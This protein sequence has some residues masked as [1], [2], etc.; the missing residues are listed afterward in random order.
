MPVTAPAH[1]GHGSIARLTAAQVPTSPAHD[2][3]PLVKLAAAV[4]P[5]PLVLVLVPLTVSVARTLRA[6]DVGVDAIAL[7]AMAGALA[8]GALLAGALLALMLSGGN[9]LAPAPGRPP[10]RQAAAAS[11][12]RGKGRGCA[13]RVPRLPQPG[14]LAAHADG[15]R[16]PRLDRRDQP[17]LL[18]V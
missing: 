18:Q 14:L 2:T 4:V 5:L 13:A 9:A 17:H 1:D 15:G 10:P 7:L 6:G 12:A 11:P 3:G 16:S 8:L